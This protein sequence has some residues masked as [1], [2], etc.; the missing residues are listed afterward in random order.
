MKLCS[1]GL[2]AAS[3]PDM[4][5]TPLT[6]NDSKFWTMRLSK[7]CPEKRRGSITSAVA[8][9]ARLQAAKR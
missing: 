1:S 6:N 3:G 7:L 4:L 9:V 2:T 8:E 5:V